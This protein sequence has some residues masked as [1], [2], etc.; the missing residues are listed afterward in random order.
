MR[1]PVF[2]D[3][4]FWIALFDSRDN[5]H[6]T[7]K[8]LS[9]SLFR[10]YRPVISDFIVFETITYLNCSLKRHDLAILFLDKLPVS[11]VEV[12]VVDDQIKTEALKIF[13]KYSDK[14]FSITDCTS[15]LVMIQNSIRKFAGFDDHFKYMGFF[16]IS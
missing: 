1:E 3:T 14:H 13:R 7:A 9:Q 16:D 10:S 11:P 15:F 5:R 4:G 12:V 2:I 8:T 6:K